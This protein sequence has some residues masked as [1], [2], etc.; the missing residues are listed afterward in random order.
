M[1][2][3]KIKVSLVSLVPGGENRRVSSHAILHEFT[4]SAASHSFFLGA[5]SLTGWGVCF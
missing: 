4:E 3:F 2:V 5:M 1:F